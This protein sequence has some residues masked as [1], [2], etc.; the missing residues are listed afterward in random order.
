MFDCMLRYLASQWWWFAI[1][2]IIA[3]I[4]GFFAGG[5]WGVAIGFGMGVAAAVGFA[6]N[7]CRWRGR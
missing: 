6:Y 4:I 3:M 2:T 7:N 5:W 1:F